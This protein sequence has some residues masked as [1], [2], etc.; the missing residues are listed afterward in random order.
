MAFNPSLPADSTKLRLAPDVIQDNWV[1][2]Q[3]GET[4]FKPKSIN[5]N[6]RTVSGPTAN[7]TAITD[8][9]LL[10]CKDDAAG[11]AELF[12]INESSQITQFT[13]GIP[14][15]G[16]PGQIYLPGGML[17]QWNSVS[18]ASG[19]TVTFSTAF[20]EAAY[21]VNFIV[22]GSPPNNRVYQRIQGTPTA[23]AFVPS[24]LDNNGSGITAT[25]NYV[26]IGR[27]T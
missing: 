1:A 25:I 26:A 12:G 21:Y 19:A 7:P 18:V 22:G 11:N 17:I 8:A 15:Y 4:S 2:I 5:L 6:N 16:K 27:V 13:R 3:D 9:F 24:I 10:Y 20:I 14:T 23:S